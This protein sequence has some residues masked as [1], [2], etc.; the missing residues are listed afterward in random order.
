MVLFLA[1]AAFAA[2][3]IVLP[4]S[5]LEINLETDTEQLVQSALQDLRAGSFEKAGRALSALAGASSGVQLR[6]LEAVS[7]YEAGQLQLA[8]N[9]ASS[10]L[11]RD[12][13]HAPLLALQG[14]VLADLGRG[15]EALT[16]L[17]SAV[18]HAGQDKGL[19]ARIELNRALV[20]LDRGEADLAAAALS[21][22]RPHAQADGD[23]E[24]LARVASNERQV[25]S[26]RGLPGATDPLGRVGELVSK[27]ELAAAKQVLPSAAAGDRR[28]KVRALIASGVIARA[29]GRMDTAQKSLQE[30]IAMA[31]EG[32]LVR[33]QA[34]AMAQ[35]GVLFSAANRPEVAM[36][37]LDNAIELLEGTTFRVLARSFQVEAG[38]AAL[39]ANRIK[40]ARAHLEAA[41]AMGPADPSSAASVAEL[42]GLVANEEG[43]PARAAAS[44]TEAA[45]G[46]EAL[47]ASLDAARCWTGLVEVHAGLDANGRGPGG[48]A[49]A[50]D[51]ALAAFEKAHD[52][53]GPAHVGIAEG[54]GRAEQ[55]DLE[56]AMT[57]FLAAATAAEA[58]GT[59][60]GKAIGKIA[61][62]NAAKTVAD[63]TNSAVVLEQADRWG[64]EELV[65]RNTVYKRARQAYDKAL[66]EYQAGRYE[67]ALAGFESATKDLESIGE[68][69]Y[70]RVARRGRAW[71]RFNA[72]THA[73]AASGLPIWQALVEEGSLLQDVE[74]RVRSMGAVALAAAELRRPEAARSL[75]A[76]AS[77]AESLGLRALAGQCHAALVDLLPKLEERILAA[78]RAFELRD[79][80]ELGVHAIYSAAFAAY[81]QGAYDKAIELAS[82]ILGIAGEHAP[83]VKEVLEA[84]KAAK[85]GG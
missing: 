28:G 19:L 4:A 6:Y 59:D 32:G 66:A 55:R 26:L 75:A 64:V 23:P 13:E 58:T 18:G 83:A 11:L 7:W 27:G 82:G 51:Q 14:L 77:E 42:A 38:R 65:Q 73:E 70:A 53:M 21:R 61:R 63:L 29:E 71:A 10:G 3:P 46:Y 9:A 36:G 81:E 68:L 22:A 8:F 76:A 37:H 35:L 50:R 47:G 78:R 43:D 79:G 40:V 31:T 69:G 74:L 56:G 17:Q 33:E 72:Y 30:A 44:L 2:E 34:A 60:Q 15:D 80:D 67:A 54:L 52:A 84:S 41:K 20:H 39:R 48:L 62:E 49:Q 85:A 5:A 24:L 25:A 16:L 45:R 1:A 57:A 12:P